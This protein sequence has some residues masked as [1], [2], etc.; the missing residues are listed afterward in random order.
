MLIAS[1]F[2]IFIAKEKKPSSFIERA[3][4]RS[5]VEVLVANEGERLL[6][7]LECIHIVAHDSRAAIVVDDVLHN[8]STLPGGMLGTLL[9]SKSKMLVYCAMSIIGLLVD[10]KGA[11]EE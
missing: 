5:L 9:T 7:V 11:A 8:M 3:V 2:K 6:P 1:I 10:V 4:V